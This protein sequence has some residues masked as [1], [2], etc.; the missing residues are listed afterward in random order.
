MQ[1]EIASEGWPI[2]VDILG[3]NEGGYESGNDG[4]RTG[5]VLPLLQ[6]TASEN[7]WA[8]WDVEYRDVI[9]LDSE[10]V[11]VGTFNLTD[12]DLSDPANYAALKALLADLAG[13]P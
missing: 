10:N 4:M 5:R 6:D 13:Q 12:H 7:A 1:A 8:D 9:L 11:R 2:E 3:V